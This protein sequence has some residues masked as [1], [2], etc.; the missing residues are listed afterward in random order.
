M[1]QE[2][3]V[4]LAEAVAAI[5]GELQQAMD[6]GEGEKLKFRTGPMEM[7][8]AVE[9]KRQVEGRLKVLVLPWTAEVKGAHGTARTHRVKVTLQPVDENGEDALISAFIDEEPA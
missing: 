8:F 6:A 4:G 9:V 2:P 1:A 7:E 3:W 5:R